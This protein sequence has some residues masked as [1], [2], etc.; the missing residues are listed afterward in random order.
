MKF[1]SSIYSGQPAGRLCQSLWITTV[2]NNNK[3]MISSLLSAT[4]ALIF[5][6]EHVLSLLWFLYWACELFLGWNIFF[7]YFDF[8]YL[9]NYFAPS[10]GPLRWKPV[11]DQSLQQLFIS[12]ITIVRVAFFSLLAYPVAIVAWLRFQYQNCSL[13]QRAIVCL[14]ITILQ[15]GFWQAICRRSNLQ[16]ALSVVQILD[17]ISNLISIFHNLW[18]YLV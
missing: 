4:A 1:L 18:I 5:R 9:V 15:K 3:K 16:I 11:E 13:R 17:I 12:T 7:S 2:C 10:A 14:F 6:L 8:F